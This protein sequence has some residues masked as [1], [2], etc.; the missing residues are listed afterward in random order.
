MNQ[1]DPIYIT[2]P[3]LPPLEHLLPYLEQIW[4]SGILTNGGSFHQAFELALCEFLEVDHVSIFSSGTIALLVALKALDVKGQVIT[5]PFSFIATSH[6]LLWNDIEPIFVDIDPTTLNIDPSAIERA[7]TPNTTA[8]LP[9]HCYGYPC[10]TERIQAIATKYDLKV[11]YDAAHAFGVR[12]HCGSIL[13]HGDLS[14]LSFHATKVFNTLEGGAVISPDEKT[15]IHIDRLKNFGFVDEVT[16]ASLG[17]N[18][19]MHEINAAIGLLQL[20]HFEEAVSKRRMIDLRY[21]QALD[22]TEGIKCLSPPLSEFHNY[23]YFPILVNDCYPLSRDQLYTKLRKNNVYARRYF[24]PLISSF[25]M[26]SHFP[27]ANPL[28]LPVATMIAEQI[29]CLPIYPDLSHHQQDKIIELIA[30]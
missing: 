26:Y 15:K 21:R 7:I 11:I 9:V 22:L 6:S 1:N 27:S 28:N 16:V 10:D 19:K 30:R 20:D 8:I 5:T 14:V 4:A 12:C 24:Y 13:S 17:L 2:K 29:L 3:I 25:P 18:G 23:S